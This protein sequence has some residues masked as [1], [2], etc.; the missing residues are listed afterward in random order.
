MHYGFG[1]NH[2]LPYGDQRNLSRVSLLLTMVQSD[3]SV[4]GDEV[5][6]LRR[7][8]LSGAWHGRVLAECKM[9]AISVGQLGTRL[10]SLEGR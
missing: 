5:S 7:S 10:L 4:Q 2:L 1:E 6:G 9:A 8:T 3:D